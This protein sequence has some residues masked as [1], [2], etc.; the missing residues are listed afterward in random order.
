MS[1]K[2]SP[3]SQS[4]SSASLHCQSASIP[5]SAP[6][7]ITA[8]TVDKEIEILL[9]RLG[10]ERRERESVASESNSKED[11]ANS[12][13]SDLD[14]EGLLSDD[15]SKVAIDAPSALVV[16]SIPPLGSYAI[17][18]S[19]NASI[20]SL[21]VQD[22]DI[23]AQRDLLEGHM[24][25]LISACQTHFLGV[26]KRLL[27]E[28]DNMIAARDSFYNQ[29][30]VKQQSII[31]NLCQDLARTSSAMEKEVARLNL[32]IGRILGMYGRRLMSHI[33]NYSVFK[34]FVNWK[35]YSTE[36]KRLNQMSKLADAFNR[37]LL[38]QRSF[39]AL[40]REH[41]AS[42]L[43]SNEK[44]ARYR[45]DETARQ[46]V[47]RYEGE[48]LRLRQ[49]AND[50]YAALRLEQFR[51]QQLEEDLRRMFLKNMTVMNMEAL[52]LFQQPAPEAPSI[53][54]SA[55]PSDV[56]AGSQQHEDPGLGRLEALREQ[57]RSQQQA[58]HLQQTR[59]HVG[60][61]EPGASS[62]SSSSS[63][64]TTSAASRRSSTQDSD[65]LQ[66][67]LQVPVRITKAVHPSQGSASGSARTKK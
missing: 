39:H 16:G 37:K 19:L 17:P 32:I 13:V 26:K 65:D 43:E 50:A 53:F 21:S 48:I 63:R 52:S 35:N 38:L 11:E 66:P 42:Q 20:S 67:R 27:E 33:G 10:T 25:A 5:S 56:S 36:R 8:A 55:P 14:S 28:R 58:L 45:F 40:V 47:E 34:I 61:T 9:E 64:P 41:F 54:I 24:I 6:L 57:M 60:S 15:D 46:L 51:R 1:G 4:E 31:E 62:S 12:S 59:G 3:S 44:E 23:Q 29:N 49:E 7:S 18:A 22:G 30:I 2:K